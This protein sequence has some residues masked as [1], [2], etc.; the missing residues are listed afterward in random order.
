MLEDGTQVM[1]FIAEPEAINA[2]QEITQL[3]GWRNYLATLKK[4]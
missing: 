3:G 1:G 4:S 2:A